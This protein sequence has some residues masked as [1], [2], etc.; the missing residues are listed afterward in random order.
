MFE[1]FNEKHQK[2]S[3]DIFEYAKTNFL[4]VRDKIESEEIIPP[5]I[6]RNMANLGWYGI[7][8]P[9][10]HQGMG[11]SHLSRFLA[12]E[13]VSRIS[14]AIGGAL[15]SAI[16]GTAMVQYYGSNTQQKK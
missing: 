5:A 9:E 11:A 4:S 3:N 15:Q 8:I 1:L 7:A 13:Q 6:Y 2:I 14:G 10:I 16:L 12:I